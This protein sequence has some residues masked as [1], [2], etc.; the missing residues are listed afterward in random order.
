ML[1]N[2]ELPDILDFLSKKINGQVFNFKIQKQAYFEV[3][4][5]KSNLYIEFI[6]KIA[7]KW[8]KFKI[9]NQKKTIKKTYT[10]FLYKTFPELFKFYLNNFFGLDGDSLELIIKDKI[11]A[12]NLTL[13]Y[14]YYLSSEEID[15]FDDFS[16][17]LK[18]NLYGVLFFTKY[19]YILVYILGII[20]RTIINE[21]I[22]ISL[23]CA[24]MNNSDDRSYLN[25]LIL[26]REDKEE[27]FINYLY[28]TLYYFLVHFNGVP[29][30]YYEKLLKS[31]EKLYQKALKEYTLAR[32]NLAD[33]LFYFYKKCK[34]LQNLCPLL[35]FL[36]FVC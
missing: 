26:I 1:I 29:D 14:N 16:N 15:Q 28:M 5:K 19:L 27:I 32:E 13:E 35:D 23:D 4:K 31:K 18:G 2:K 22:F 9:K 12:T 6:E 7:I 10:T 21:K 17:K 30:E 3:L 34:L 25:F 20:I 33:L 8:R 24:A 11:S 36:N